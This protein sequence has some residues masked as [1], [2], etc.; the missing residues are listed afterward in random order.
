LVSIK[1]L[2]SK[3]REKIVGFPSSTYIRMKM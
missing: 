1:L 3:K 2:V